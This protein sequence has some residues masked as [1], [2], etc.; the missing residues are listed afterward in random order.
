MLRS[1]RARIWGIVLALI[2]VE[3][4][5]RILGGS[6]ATVEV[7]N[8]G[9]APIEDLRVVC[10][11]SE[12]A[13]GR[14]EVGQTARLLV[15]ARGPSPLRMTFQQPHCMISAI[16][17]EEFDPGYLQGQGQRLVIGIGDGETYRYCEDNPGLI[18]RVRRTFRDLSARIP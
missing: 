6:R 14:I 2:A 15:T 17:V 16:E 13:P 7:V 10:D 4:G 5:V 12:V 18:N 3:V 9:S 8:K 1:R 11:G